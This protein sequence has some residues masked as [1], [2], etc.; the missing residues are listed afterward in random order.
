MNAYD[1]S[2]LAREMEEEYRQSLK[3]CSGMVVAAIAIAVFV[4]G[5]FLAFCCGAALESLILR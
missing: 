1:R 2:R 4:M 5:T 3:G